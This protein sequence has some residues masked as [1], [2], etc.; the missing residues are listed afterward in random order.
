MAQLQNLN[1]LPVIIA[2]VAAWIFGA[3]YYGVLGKAWLAA[4]GT[5]MEQTKA[6]NAG[7]SAAAKTTPFVL[8]FVAE[9][10]MAVAMSGILFHIGIY[11]LGAGLFSAA[12]I[13]VGFVLTTIAVNNAYAFRSIR[14]TAID[15][16]HW[17]GALLIIG[18]ILGWMGR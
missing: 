14:L 2:A 5:T 9:I 10:V 15:A 17:L 16:G 8:S 11:G 6:A 1:W 7:K 4:Q 12:M 13:W 3:V 18:G